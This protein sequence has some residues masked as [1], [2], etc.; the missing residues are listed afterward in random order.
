MGLGAYGMNQAKQ[1][2]DTVSSETEHI[3][4]PEQKQNLATQSFLANLRVNGTEIPEERRAVGNAITQSNIGV[5]NA[6][7]RLAGMPNSGATDAA[8][9]NVNEAAI[10]AR[11]D[12]QNKIHQHFYDQAHQA[13]MQIGLRGPSAG[14]KYT[15]PNVGKQQQAA[16]SGQDAAAGLSTAIAAAAAAA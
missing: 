1:Q 13:A 16:S 2:P 3:M 4:T 11:I 15:Q 10:K 9:N 8:Y 7:M 6:M 5:R 12:A 14:N